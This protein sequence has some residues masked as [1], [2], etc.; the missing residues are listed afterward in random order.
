[1]PIQIDYKKFEQ[2]HEAFLQYMLT[3][4]DGEP[5]VNFQHSFLV[6]DE[7]EYK[8]I[9][10]GKAKDALSLENWPDWKKRPKE[11]IEAV[12]ISCSPSVSRNLLYHQK[13]FQNSSEA[14]L[15]RVET[16][17]E[18]RRLTEQL[19]NFFLAGPST[20][21]DFGPRFDSLANYLRQNSL[22]CNWRFLAYLSFLLNNEF[23]FPIVPENF[24]ALLDFYEIDRR[25]SG[26]VS[27]ERYE[28]LLEMAKLLKQKLA[29]YGQA[30]MI[31]IQSYMWVV[32]YLV[33]EETIPTIPKIAPPDYD[34]ELKIRQNRAQERERI[35]LLGERYI[36]E[37][38]KRKLNEIGR[39]D[40]ASR[41]ELIS[42]RNEA[43]GYD[44]LSFTPTEEEI[45]IEVKATSYPPN[46][47]PGF[48]LSDGEKLQA[49]NDVCWCLYRVWGIDTSPT[50]ENLGNI[51]LNRN[52]NW[53]LTPSNWY[54]RSN[55]FV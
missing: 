49:E 55:L 48:W 15:Y 22:G 37:Q 45:H 3:Q 4:S 53:E 54:V 27:W 50:F 42:L 40:L 52:E 26:Y 1:M 30:S 21:I 5:F 2:G 10:Y 35:G 47:D 43:S 12:K 51:I 41:V 31:E 46:R 6:A 16:D 32:S 20:P 11:I 33:K 13:G 25:I 7:I 23:Y 29:I 8:K 18:I 34:A 19:I 9:V 17:G 14:A 44:V 36:F 28:I 38:E 39:H 24:D